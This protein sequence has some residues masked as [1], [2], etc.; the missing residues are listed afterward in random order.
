V[1]ERYRLRWW[2]KLRQGTFKQSSPYNSKNNCIALAAGDS[3]KWWDASG[4]WPFQESD[5][6]IQ[7]WANVFTTFGYK[8]CGLDDS[9]EENF[10]KVAIY[11]RTNGEPMHMARQ[12]QNGHWLSKLGRNVDIEHT[13]LE[14]LSSPINYGAV[15][16]ILR[17]KK[18]T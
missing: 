13:T 1:T 17:R 3:K 11:A 16:L 15:V 14:V 8:P 5:D 6:T 10:E 12:L 9:L 2:P 4:H 18:G 7:G